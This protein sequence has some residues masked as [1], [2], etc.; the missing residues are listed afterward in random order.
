M[1]KEFYTSFSNKTIK[2]LVKEARLLNAIDHISQWIMK[3]L[4][5]SELKKNSTP[6]FIVV[7][8]R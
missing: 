1:I 8:E 5:E 2:V 4:N 3:R 7:K 6:F